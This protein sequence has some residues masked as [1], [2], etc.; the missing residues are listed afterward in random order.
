MAS[1]SQFRISNA[2]NKAPGAP[3]PDLYLSRLI[4]LIPS[5][6]TA[7]YVCGT[8]VIG[9]EKEPTKGVWALFCLAAVVM[10]RWQTTRAQS[11]TQAP[12]YLAILISCISFG[13]WVFA[14]G[15]GPFDKAAFR[16]PEVT[17]LLMIGWTFL[18][19][20]LYKGDQA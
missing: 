14:L 17:T 11:G 6:V 18:V 1:M 15:D 2:V 7:L 9:S 20:Y 19:P 12:Q 8:G 3:G 4:K 5:E 16:T 13:I 10:I